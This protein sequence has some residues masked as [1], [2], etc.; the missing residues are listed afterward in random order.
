[1]HVL[2]VNFRGDPW[3]SPLILYPAAKYNPQDR[4]GVGRLREM[5]TNVKPDV[6]FILQD[7]YT[8]EEG[9]KALGGKFGVPTVF[10]V[11]VDG[12][13]VPKAWWNTVKAVDVAVA[14][15][16]HGQR[17]IKDEAGL[18]VDVLVH[19]VE[20]EVL[21][22]VTPERP[23][24]INRNAEQ[25]RVTNK[26][27][28]KELLGVRGRFLILAINRN[29]IRKNYYD[30]FRLFDRLHRAHPDAF[31]YIHA[32]QKDEG[33]DLALLMERYGLTPKEVWIHNAG[34]TYLG[35]EKPLLAWLYNAADVKLSTAMAEGFGLTDAE[36]L[37]CGTPVI[38]QDFSATSD[39]VGPGGILVPIQRYFTTARMVDMALIDL[40]A[41]Y[42]AL[43]R[44]YSDPELRKQL[45]EKAAIYAKR[46]NWDATAEGFYRKFEQLLAK[47]QPGTSSG[48]SVG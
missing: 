7:M 33:G 46:Y 29:S 25:H 10:Y 22:P 36:A 42:E 9:L 15:A 4:F 21:Y 41:A 39:V 48:E 31:L 1:M 47:N 18:D 34:D 28:A 2:A 8:V 20:N 5:I 27:E 11:P 32:V 12:I 35:A 43:E 24:I 16:E 14:M 45:G 6:L 17:I 19:G 38:A 13:R 30:T 23:L 3:P 44:F 40:E 26:E 37:A